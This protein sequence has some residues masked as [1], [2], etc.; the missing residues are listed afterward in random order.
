M[1][2][3]KSL[4][5]AVENKDI[6]A[7]RS[8]FYTIILS[9]PRFKTSKFDEALQY[10]KAHNL[11]GFIDVH[12]G[13]ELKPESEWDEEYFDIISSKLQDNFSEERITQLK[14]VARGLDEAKTYEYVSRDKRLSA[15]EM[16]QKER[17][18]RSTSNSYIRKTHVTSEDDYLGLWTAGAIVAMGLILI[19]LIKG[20]K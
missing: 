12:D 10:V 4:K 6:I 20:G 3:S 9:D 18:K 17:Q 5:K 15:Q 11:D 16:I 7:I 2:I 19:R 14:K 13:E 8:S 1:L